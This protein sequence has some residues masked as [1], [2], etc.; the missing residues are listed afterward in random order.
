MLKQL[1]FIINVENSNTF[2]KHD[3]GQ[4]K[5]HGLIEIDIFCNIKNA[6]PVAFGQF[7]ASLLLSKNKELIVLTSNFWTVV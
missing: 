3:T 1:L 7:K 4:K 2:A 5:E 6:F